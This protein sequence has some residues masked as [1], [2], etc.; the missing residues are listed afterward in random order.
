MIGGFAPE[1]AVLHVV[2]QSLDMTTHE[3]MPLTL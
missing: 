1:L 3:A 2:T